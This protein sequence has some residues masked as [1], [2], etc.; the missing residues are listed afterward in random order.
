MHTYIVLFLAGVLIFVLVLIGA[1]NSQIPG[2][3]Q[4]PAGGGGYNWRG[5]IHR[6]PR[7]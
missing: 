5:Q 3:W 1:V 2:E 7:D 6:V 4:L